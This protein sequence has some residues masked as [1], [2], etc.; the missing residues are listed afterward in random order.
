MIVDRTAHPVI[1]EAGGPAQ[2]AGA[3]VRT[4]EGDGGIFTPRSSRRRSARRTVTRRVRDWSWVEQTTNSAAAG[5]G[6]SRVEEVLD[7]AR[8]HRLRAHLDGARLLNAVVH[9]GVSG[10]EYAS[11]F[12]TAWIDFTKGL[13][14]RSE[15]CSPGRAS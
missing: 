14:R 4:V 3:M 15:P 11:G 6:R 5:Y 1:A 2:L 13:A 10:G 7:V 8:R 9:S 12:D